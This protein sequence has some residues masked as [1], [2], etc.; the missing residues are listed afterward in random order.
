MEKDFCLKHPSLIL[1]KTVKDKDLYLFLPVTY[2]KK[3]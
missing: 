3:Q 2:L 1:K